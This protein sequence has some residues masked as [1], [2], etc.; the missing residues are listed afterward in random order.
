M[1]LFQM[2]FFSSKIIQ[3]F[4]QQRKN[5]NLDLVID[6]FFF[7]NLVHNLETKVCLFNI[8]WKII[9]ILDKQ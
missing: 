6:I 7:I 8:I 2:Y 1:D 4:Q 9:V 3:P 5:C